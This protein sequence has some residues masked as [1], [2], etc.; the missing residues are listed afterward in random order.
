MN[1][2][3]V[4]LLTLWGAALALPLA[5]VPIAVEPVHAAQ[6]M[7]VA[8]HPEVAQIGVAVLRRGGNAVDAAVAV[9]LAVGVAEPYGSGLG[10]KLSLL[11]FDAASGRTFAVDAMDQASWSLQPETFAKLP[12]DARRYGWSSVCVPGLAA[13]LDAVHRRWGARPWA[14]NIQPAIELARGGFTILPKSHSLFAEKL[15]LLRRGD[16]E[17]A[18]LY[19]PQGRLP[20]VGS[21]LPNPDLADAMALLA[22]DGAEAFYRGPIAAAIVAAARQGGGILTLEDFARYEA[23]IVEPVRAAWLGLE[24]AGAP[25]PCTGAALVLPMLKVLED[26]TWRGPLRSAENLDRI[27]RVWQQVQP[28]VSRLIADV[29]DARERFAELIGPAFVAEARRKSRPGSTP[30]PVELPEEQPAAVTAW[31]ADLA[32]QF[33]PEPFDVHASTT[34][35]IVVD[36]AGNIVCATQ[37]QSLHFGA[38]VVAPGTGIVLN[39]SMSNFA[40]ANPRSVNYAAPGKRPRSTITPTI[41]L[42][43]GRPVLALGIPGSQRIP[44]AVAQVLLDHFAFGRSLAD[45]IGATRLHLLNPV[46]A[47]DP[48]NVFEVEES[49]PAEVEAGLR[50]LGWRVKREEPAGTG[51]HFGGMNAVELHADG[52]RTGYADPRRTNAAIGY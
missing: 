8:A 46:G 41:V 30:A 15:D 52:T 44:T 10:G 2:R 40:Y 48:N 33:E 1:L 14:E 19:L 51:E 3:G 16:P 38:G 29:P 31:L 35:F 12:S 47:S 39:D 25:P 49:L 5:A 32:G 20:E 45:A 37:S 6:G 22:R 21:R 28:Q 11:Y 9:S 42:R 13:G 23:R 50:Q 34:H 7:V 27:G 43:D 4:F 36:A 18:R 24:I 26:E 17:I